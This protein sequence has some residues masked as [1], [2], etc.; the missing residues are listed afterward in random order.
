MAYPPTPT[1]PQRKPNEEEQPRQTP[2]DSYPLQQPLPPSNPPRPATPPPAPSAMPA[3]PSGFAAARAKASVPPPPLPPQQAPSQTRTLTNQAPT[4]MQ[5]PRASQHTGYRPPPTNF[6]NFAQRFSANAATSHR[7][8]DVLAKQAS[9][10]EHQADA[11][12]KAAQDKF[13]AGI[14]AGT[15]ANPYQ[16]PDVGQS[17]AAL[18]AANGPAKPAAS[19]TATSPAQ[20]LIKARQSNRT[21]M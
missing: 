21:A 9:G 7:E 10:S 6:T 15:V 17:S 2:G 18:A 13:K 3:P 14:D 8:A 1:R 16:T 19:T 5:G 4:V 20:I 12:L 11:A